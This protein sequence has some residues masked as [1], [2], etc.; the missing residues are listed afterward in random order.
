MKA[1]VEL[2]SLR[3]KESLQGK[4]EAAEAS[5]QSLA[6][7]RCNHRVTDLPKYNTKSQLKAQ[8]KL[9]A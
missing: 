9:H 7:T 6:E 2:T 8:T 5:M 3:W 4:H 1:K